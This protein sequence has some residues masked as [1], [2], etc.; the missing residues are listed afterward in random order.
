MKYYK[1]PRTY[2]LPYSLGASD[3]DKILP[4][5]EI[6]RNKNVVVTVKMDGENTTISKNKVY[7]RSVDSRHEWYHSWLL[8][9]SSRIQYNI[10]E[11]ERICGEYLYC[12]HSIKYTNLLSY[13]MGFSMWNE[14]VCYNW[15]D[16]VHLFN[17]LDI[18]PVP[19]LYRGIYNREIVEKIFHDVIKSG[20]EGIVVRNINSFKYEDFSA[21]VA[22]CV[23]PNHVQT[24]TH[25]RNSNIEK[26]D[27]S[28]FDVQK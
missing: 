19:W 12:K 3:D 15:D 22:K 28:Q 11:N 20:D 6:F 1:Y 8:N 7:A 16:T 9:F 26:N 23:R 2:H 17:F 4:D 21:N 14:D 13:F 24:D 10:H 27:L 25:W 5:D 18:K